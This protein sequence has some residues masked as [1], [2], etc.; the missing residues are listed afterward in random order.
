MNHDER[1]AL[2]R[3]AEKAEARAELAEAELREARRMMRG[4]VALGR[5]ELDRLALFFHGADQGEERVSHEV[6]DLTGVDSEGFLPRTGDG[7]GIG[8]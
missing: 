6:I 2:T 7:Y 5:V 4:L 1:E 8:R 3:R